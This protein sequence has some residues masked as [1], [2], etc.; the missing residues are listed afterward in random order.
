MEQHTSYEEHLRLLVYSLKSSLAVDLCPGD[1]A[2]IPSRSLP[3]LRPPLPRRWSPLHHPGPG[4]NGYRMPANLSV[5]SLYFLASTGPRTCN[6]PFNSRSPRSFT[7]TISSSSS[8][9]KS[10]GSETG[11]PAPSSTS[12]IVNRFSGCLVGKEGRPVLCFVAVVDPKIHSRP[13]F[14]GRNFLTLPFLQHR[15]QT[16]CCTVRS[17]DLHLHSNNKTPPPPFTNLHHFRLRLS[18]PLRNSIR[19]SNPSIPSSSDLQSI[20]LKP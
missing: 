3:H 14:S 20:A 7:N 17:P 15:E 5:L 10:R 18:S 6:L 19:P 2:P 16:R 12:A 8:R 11:A 4:C 9:T 13:C 1:F